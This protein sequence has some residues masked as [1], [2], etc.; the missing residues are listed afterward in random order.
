MSAGHVDR[1][2]PSGAALP[3]PAWLNTKPL[4]IDI[5]SAG[6]V[7]HRVHRS[8]F[9]PIFF[10]PGKG[11]LP[12]NRFDSASGRFGVLY[13]GMT[14]RGALAETILRNPQRL[15]VAASDVTS[16]AATELCVQRDLRIA[17]MHGPGLQ[18]LGTDNAISTGPYEPCGQWADA[19][20]DHP[21]K[22]DGLAYQSRHDPGEVCIAL[23]ERPDLTITVQAT[24]LLTAMLK[25][26][27]ALLDGYGKS[28]APGP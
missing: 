12:I 20:W 24:R 1:R 9:L 23:F 17:R 25:D 14:L 26:V 3:P 8:T 27:A 5:L 13:L 18:A 28:I 19:L 7:L 22:P 11:G 4:P 21:D 16:R 6:Q 10:G 15:M 2:G